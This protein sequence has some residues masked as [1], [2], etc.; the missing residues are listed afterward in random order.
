MFNGFCGLGLYDD[1]IVFVLLILDVR[2]I[3]GLWGFCLEI[4]FFLLL[5]ILWSIFFWI[6]DV[7]FF[8]G[9]WEEGWVFNII[10]LESIFCFEFLIFKVLFF[11][12][13]FRF[14]G[15]VI[16]FVLILGKVV[17]FCL[18]FFFLDVCLF[19]VVL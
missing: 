11:L 6:I 4:L 14:L 7:L 3:R 13:W 10:C 15:I 12:D 17:C 18:I 1:W 19:V 5:Y 2:L 16:V 8:N 9:F